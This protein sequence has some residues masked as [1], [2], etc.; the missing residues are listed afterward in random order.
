M[1]YR[2]ECAK[3]VRE[4]RAL[5]ESGHPDSITKGHGASS[6]GNNRWPRTGT[7]T[8][9][10]RYRS[11][12]RWTI[13]RQKLNFIANCTIRGGAA[14]TTCPNEELPSTLFTDEGPKN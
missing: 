9:M 10:G 3:C 12:G 2:K 7:A 5:S 13:S 14:L 1:T 6:D 11:T 4:W 8:D